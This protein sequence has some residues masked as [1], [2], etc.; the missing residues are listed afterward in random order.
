MRSIKP[1]PALKAL[2][3]SYLMRPAEAR[4]SAEDTTIS[5]PF[6]GE[7]AVSCRLKELKLA[8]TNNNGPKRAFCFNILEKKIG[9]RGRVSGERLSCERGYKLVTRPASCSRFMTPIDRSKREVETRRSCQ[10]SA[11][12]HCRNLRVKTLGCYSKPE[13]YRACCPLNMRV[14]YQ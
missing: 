12:W 5:L 4:A 8:T 13:T 2:R 6:S 1:A 9:T 10:V 3:A 7:S 14:A 11:I